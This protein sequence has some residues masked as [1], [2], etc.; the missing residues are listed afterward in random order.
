M[1][2][3]ELGKAFETLAEALKLTESEITEEVKVIE[4]QIEELKGRIV[5]LNAKQETLAHD[6]ESLSE[7]FSRYSATEDGAQ[8]I[9]F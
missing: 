7:M 6:R 5:E 9:E 8:K 1:A 4:Q 3:S 2:E